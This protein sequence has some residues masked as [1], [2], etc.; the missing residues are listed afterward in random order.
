MGTQCGVQPPVLCVPQICHQMHYL[1][2]FAL[3]PA[4]KPNYRSFFTL[5]QVYYF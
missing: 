1:Y 4:T 2:N 5:V 3:I